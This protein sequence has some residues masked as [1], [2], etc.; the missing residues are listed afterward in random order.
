MALW[1]MDAGGNGFSEWALAGLV[2]AGYVVVYIRSQRTLQRTIAELRREFDERNAALL[3]AVQESAKTSQAEMPPTAPAAPSP[4]PSTTAPATPAA[5]K[6]EEVTPEMLLVIAAAVT[7]YLGKKV[8]VRSARIIYS[9][10]TFNP[11]SQ[12]GRVFVQASHNL[13]QRY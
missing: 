8:R 13:T 11:W 2:I 4:M 5:E 10:E 7:A 12:Q 6:R 1:L 9:P 3:A